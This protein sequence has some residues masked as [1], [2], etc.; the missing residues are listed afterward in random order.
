MKLFEKSVSFLSLSL[1]G[2]SLNNATVKIVQS[3]TN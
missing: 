1:K 3:Y 2:F